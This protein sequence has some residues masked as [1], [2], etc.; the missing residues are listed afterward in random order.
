MATNGP[1]LDDVEGRRRRVRSDGAGQAGDLQGLSDI[2]DADSESVRELLEEGQAFEAA[3]VS[4]VENAPPADVEEVE[5][6]EVPE[7]DVPEEYFEHDPDEP[8]E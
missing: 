4:G 1:S 3:V 6:S 8:R 7:D 5:T 2:A